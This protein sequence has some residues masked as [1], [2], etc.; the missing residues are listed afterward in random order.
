[1]LTR[2]ILRYPFH[3][4]LAGIGGSSLFDRRYLFVHFHLELPEAAVGRDAFRARSVAAADVPLAHLDRDRRSDAGFVAIQDFNTRA[5]VGVV[6]EQLGH[7]NAAR[8][9]LD[10]EASVREHVAALTVLDDRGMRRLFV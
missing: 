9:R 4:G 6:G 1:M 2:L 8:R 5:D 7:Q 3:V 10:P